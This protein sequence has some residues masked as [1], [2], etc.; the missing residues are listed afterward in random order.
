ML[1]SGYSGCHVP[2]ARCVTMIGLFLAVYQQPL[3]KV[4]MIQYSILGHL[5][6]R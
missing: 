2:F 1:T 6:N 4:G 5:I 3:V